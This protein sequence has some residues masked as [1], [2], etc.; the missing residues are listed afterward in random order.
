MPA[1]A[2]FAFAALSGVALPVVLS[3]VFQ[4]VRLTS[5]AGLLTEANAWVVTAFGLGAAAASLAAG[6][7][8]DQLPA[9]AAIPAVIIAASLVTATVCGL[10]SR[11]AAPDRSR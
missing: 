1:G 7:V 5:P 10:A 2:W 6:L 3:V 8:T 9:R 11:G 4:R